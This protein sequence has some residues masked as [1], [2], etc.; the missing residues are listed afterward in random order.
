L[1]CRHVWFLRMFL[2]HWM[3]LVLLA[4]RSSSSRQT[5]PV[6]QIVVNSTSPQQNNNKNSKETI[7]SKSSESE[8]GEDVTEIPKTAQKQSISCV[9]VASSVLEICRICHCEAEPDQPL[10]SPCHCSGSLR[11]VHQS[12]LQ[13]W[14]KSSDTKKCELCYYEFVMEAKMKPFRKWQALEM[15]QSERRKIMCSVSFHVIAIT[16][17]VWSLWVLIER[18]AQEIH[19]GQLNWPFWTKLVVVAIGFTGGLVFMYVQCKVYVQLWKRLKAY[20]RIILVQNSVPSLDTAEYIWQSR[21]FVQNWTLLDNW[22][23]NESQHLVIATLTF[24]FK[25]FSPVQIVCVVL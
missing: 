10:I 22:C 1:N 6:H 17:V 4:P 2:E 8:I 14:I 11:Y 24:V 5:M 23:L 13:K 9:S 12:C 7:K 19:D 3:S 20:N 21:W 18:T 15:T 16:C 25:L